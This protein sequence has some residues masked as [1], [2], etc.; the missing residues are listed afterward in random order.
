MNLFGLLDRSASRFGDRPAAFVGRQLSFTYEQ[1]RTRALA[2]A[3]ALRR[4]YAVGDRI[5]VAST[6]CPE[7]LVIM[8]G[9]WA[10]GMVLAPINAKLHPREVGDILDDAGARLLFAS[11]HVCKLLGDTDSKGARLVAIASPEFFS[12]VEGQDADPA[13]VSANALAWLFYT[14][15][16]TGRPKGAMLSHRNLLAMTLAHLADFEDISEDDCIIHAAPMS[17]GSGLYVLPYLARAARHVVP[18]SAGFDP[19]EFLDLCGAHGGCGAFMAPTMLRRLRLEAERTGRGA[20]NLRSIIYGGGPMYVDEIRR[21]LA[22]FGPI[23][24]QLYGQ[25]EAPMTITGMRRR[26]FADRSDASL[27]SVGWPRTGVEVRILDRDDA[28][29]G[30]GA[31]GE[32]LCRGDVV[33]TGYWNNADATAQALKGGWLRTGDI[34][35]L[36]ARGRLTLLDRSKEVIISGGTNIYPREVEETLL[37]HPAVREVAVLGCKDIEWGETV[38]AFIALEP[39]Q[40]TTP[41]QLDSFCLEKIARFKRPKIYAFVDE[42]PK[43]AYGKVLKRAL[44]DQIVSGQAVLLKISYDGPRVTRPPLTVEG[45]ETRCWADSWGDCPAG[46]PGPGDA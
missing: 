19:T 8:F 13:D 11:A 25:G 36:D 34:G 42:L 33:M 46:W 29:A 1:L 28:E 10:A 45:H 32:I 23:F 35:S 12:M 5:A 24:S 2:L 16:T 18:S 43:S 38:T 37:C 17:H 26:D 41:E 7:Y 14:S 6:N 15:G 9:V 31:P 22:C 21:A 30:E 20:P 3:H 27:G 39:G 4:D 40:K 44:E